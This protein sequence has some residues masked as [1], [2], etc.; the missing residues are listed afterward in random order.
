MAGRGRLSATPGF[1]KK[2]KPSLSKDLILQL[3]PVPR[4]SDLPTPTAPILVANEIQLNDKERLVCRG[5]MPPQLKTKRYR[6]VSGPKNVA[7][8]NCSPR[9]LRFWDK[10]LIRQFSESRENFQHTCQMIWPEDVIWQDLLR[11]SCKWKKVP[12]WSVFI[13][14]KENNNLEYSSVFSKII[15]ARKQKFKTSCMV[16]WII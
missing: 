11:K 4:F 6:A 10:K 5:F 1:W 15:W 3:P 8:I 14:K 7:G 13:F 2:A 9:L 12:N 16:I